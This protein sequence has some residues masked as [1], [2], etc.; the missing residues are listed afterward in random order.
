[1]SP[2]TREVSSTEHASDFVPVSAYPYWRYYEGPDHRVGTDDHSRDCCAGSCR[3]ARMARIRIAARPA[4]LPWN[5]RKEHGCMR[6]SRFS[7]GRMRDVHCCHE[8]VD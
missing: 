2:M 7:G 5:G 8:W 3:R 4:L 6:F 1:M